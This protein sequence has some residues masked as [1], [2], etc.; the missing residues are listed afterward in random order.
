MESLVSRQAERNL[1]TEAGHSGDVSTLTL[2]KHRQEGCELGDSLGFCPGLNYF[3]KFIYFYF[4][5]VG[6]LP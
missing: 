5:C 1:S 3:L 6:V 4:I 2:G